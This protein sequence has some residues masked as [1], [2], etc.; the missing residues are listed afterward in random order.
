MIKKL[1][2]KSENNILSKKKFNKLNKNNIIKNSNKEL[3]LI[4]LLLYTIALGFVIEISY[5]FGREI[6]EIENKLY[7]IF[8]W[9]FILIF[10]IF[11][12]YKLIRYFLNKD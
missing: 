6:F 1:I 9:F 10:F 7:K 3:Y 8:L 11:C 2:K 12:T 5:F 4:I